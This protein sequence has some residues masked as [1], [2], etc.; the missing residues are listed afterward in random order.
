[1]AGI[2]CRIEETRHSLDPTGFLG[3]QGYTEIGH[4]LHRERKKGKVER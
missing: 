4:R 3:A 1:M 2:A